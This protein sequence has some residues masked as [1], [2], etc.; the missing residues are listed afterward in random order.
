MVRRDYPSLPEHEF[1]L[2]GED[3][4]EDMVVWI[5]VERPSGRPYKLSR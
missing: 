3:L 1:K 4:L 5:A 2:M